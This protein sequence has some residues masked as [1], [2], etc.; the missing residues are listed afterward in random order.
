MTKPEYTQKLYDLHLEY[1]EEKQKLERQIKHLTAKYFDD[2]QEITKQFYNQ[3][4]TNNE[5][6]TTVGH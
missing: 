4:N 2:K 1:W 6:T 5:Q 3:K